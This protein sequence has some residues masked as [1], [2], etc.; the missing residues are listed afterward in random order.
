M[1][2]CWWWKSHAAAGLD[3][4]MLG[5]CLLEDAMPELAAASADDDRMWRTVGRLVKKE[6][7]YGLWIW[8]WLILLPA[9]CCL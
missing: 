9:C 3:L 8:L 7:P 4:N 2:G 5:Q 6:Q 1:S